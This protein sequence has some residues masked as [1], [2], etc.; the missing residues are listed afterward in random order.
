MLAQSNLQPITNHSFPP[1][2]SPSAD[3]AELALVP[4]AQ[5]DITPL[6]KPQALF[7]L[8]RDVVFSILSHGG[9]NIRYGDC[10]TSIEADSFFIPTFSHSD[11][12]QAMLVKKQLAT[13]DMSL[14]LSA[15]IYAPNHLM[16]TIEAVAGSGGLMDMTIHMDA[17]KLGEMQLRIYTNKAGNTNMRITLANGEMLDKLRLSTQDLV[18]LLLEHGHQPGGEIEWH[19]SQRVKSAH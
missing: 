3:I 19:S 9:S 13:L 2:L 4:H 6:P 11:A 12:N 15:T 5:A 14:D 8:G 7:T 10:T 17:K 18:E 16:V 1:H